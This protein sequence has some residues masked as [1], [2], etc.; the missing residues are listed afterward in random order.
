MTIRNEKKKKKKE[1]NRMDTYNLKRA[2]PENR[3][4]KRTGQT[5]LLSKS[6]N[7]IPLAGVS[8]QG[9]GQG[10]AVW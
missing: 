1:K 6:N 7:K 5:T 2:R 10:R 4:Q 9:Q 8:G 3:K